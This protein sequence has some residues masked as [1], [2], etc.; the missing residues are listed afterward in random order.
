MDIS[1]LFLVLGALIAGF[2]ATTC[3]VLSTPSLQWPGVDNVVWPTAV[4]LFVISSIAT[5]VPI[6][7]SGKRAIAASPHKRS[8]A[9][10]Y[11]FVALYTAIGICTVVLI[12]FRA[13]SGI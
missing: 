13:A 1:R 3:V 11:F 7:P 12:P 4:A 10:G 5:S 2:V 9:I 8:F 6:V